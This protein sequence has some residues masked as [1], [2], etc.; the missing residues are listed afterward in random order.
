MAT[1]LGARA[2]GLEKEIG[3]LEAGKRADLITLSLDAPH[4]VPLYNIYSQIVYASKASDVRDVMV[5]GRLL[6]RDRQALTLDSRQVLA[7]A[8]EFGAKVRASLAPAR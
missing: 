8:E 1:R 2:L 4:T 7:K 5:N 3:S 6:V